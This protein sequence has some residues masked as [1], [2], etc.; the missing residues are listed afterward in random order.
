MRRFVLVPM[1]AV[2]IFG[3]LVTPVA[4][5]EDPGAVTVLRTYDADAGQLPEGLAVDKRG[6]LYLTMPFVGE[7]RRIDPDGTEQ[8]VAHL[9]TGGGFGPLG[10]AVDAPGNVYAGVVTFDAATHG[11][12]RV[13]PSGQ[14][15]RLPGSEAIGFPNGVAFGDRGT[16]YVADSMGAVWRIP[17]G[18]SAELW[19]R[20]ATLTGDGSAPPPFPI[21]ANGIT[22]RHGIVYV[23]NTE[24]GSIIK[25]PVLPDGSPGT[26][27]V[28]VQSPAL[29]A[30][31][32][33]ALD[34]HGGIYVAVIAQSTIVR[35]SPDGQVI[36]VLADGSDGLDFVSSIAFG[37]GRGERTT[38]YAVNFSTG[39]FFGSPRVHPPAL[40]S[41]DVG[42]PGLPQ[43]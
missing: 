37:T 27:A 8:V 12:W 40:L 29:G 39:P 25:I 13:T 3:T 31:D 20:D 43:P 16:L 2:L 34:V 28:L 30:A 7:L 38:L 15:N 9:P 41:M 21:G 33:I 35:V 14:T 5:A 6:R 17:R 24:L 19:I 32:G 36:D 18:G 10:L 23:T 1:L 22:Y 26:P 11:V 4:R 42:V